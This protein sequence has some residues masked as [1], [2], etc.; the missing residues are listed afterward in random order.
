MYRNIAV[1][2]SLM[3][4]AVSMP[5]YAQAIDLSAVN[6]VLQSVLDALT[7]L[8][9]RL[10]MTIVAVGVLMAGAFNFLDWTRVFTLLFI[11]VVIGVIPTFVQAIWGTA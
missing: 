10:V 3:V 6:S 11:I 7:G 2:A 4:L 5:A 8:T 1:M 9:G